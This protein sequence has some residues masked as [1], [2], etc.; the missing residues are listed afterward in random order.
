MLKKTTTLTILAVLL[1]TGI[2]GIGIA[3]DNES[4][5]FELRA[6]VMDIDL[7]YNKI[8][9]AEEEMVL[10]S[11]FENNKTVWDTLFLDADGN[12]ISPESI[13]SGSRVSVRGDVE[14]EVSIAK[15]II[16]LE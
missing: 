12:Q 7:T 11:H 3:D 1:Y 8:V 2:C 6:R 4:G 16:L 9:I 10:L 14:N 15:E 5:A 13:E